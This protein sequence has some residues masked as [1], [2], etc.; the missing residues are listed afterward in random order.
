[1]DDLRFMKFDFE[2]GLVLDELNMTEQ[3]IS[4][5]G[6]PKKD[7]DDFYEKLEQKEEI[8]RLKRQ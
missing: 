1:M 4:L 5:G 8:K 6:T 3:S 2:R 7:E